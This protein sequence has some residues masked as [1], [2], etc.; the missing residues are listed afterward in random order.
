M[1]FKLFPGRD[2]LRGYLVKTAKGPDFYE[3]VVD[4]DRPGILEEILEKINQIR[5]VRSKEGKLYE[6]A[7]EVCGH[8]SQL[9]LIVR[10]LN[11]NFLAKKAA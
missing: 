2:F 11:K 3:L 6:L 9:R 1:L 8:P 7:Q 5:S 4:R 10:A